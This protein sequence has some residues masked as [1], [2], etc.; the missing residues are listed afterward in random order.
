V[1]PVCHRQIHALN[2]KVAKPARAS[3]L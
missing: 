1:H 2:L 3:G